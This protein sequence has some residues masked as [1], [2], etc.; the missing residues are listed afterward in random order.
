ML[1][2]WWLIPSHIE[3]QYDTWT[4]WLIS[5]RFINKEEFIDFGSIARIPKGEF[6]GAGMWQ[7]YKAIDAPYKSVLKLQLTEL[8]AAELPTKFNLSLEFKQQVYRGSGMMSIWTPTSCSIVGWSNTL[9]K[10]STGEA[11]T[12][13]EMFLPQGGE[14]LS[15]RVSGKAQLLASGC[16]AAFSE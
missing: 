9:R 6:V 11:D 14:K 15:A 2:L 10:R 5:N 3:H 7:L 4:D 1:P 16:H 13:P 8:Y 12:G